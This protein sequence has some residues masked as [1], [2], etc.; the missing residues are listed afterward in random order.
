MAGVE[1]TLPYCVVASSPRHVAVLS[2]RYSL[3]ALRWAKA[4]LGCSKKASASGKISGLFPVCFF[5]LP[6]LST[7][8][9]ASFLA[10]FFQQVRI[11]NNFPALFF[12]LFRFVFSGRT[13]VIS[14]FSALFF[15]ITSFFVPFVPNPAVLKAEK[16]L[17][18]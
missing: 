15:K 13:F 17:P 5:W 8:C 3:R 12:G 6:L 7:R 2:R 9:S 16:R 1:F 4:R 18:C 11:F 14:N 10:L